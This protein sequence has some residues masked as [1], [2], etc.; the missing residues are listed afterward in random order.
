M[1]SRFRFR[2]LLYLVVA[3]AISPIHAGVYEDFFKG[4]ELDLERRVA[5]LLARGFD[6]NTLSEAGQTPL[7]LALRDGS[8]KVTQ[9]L[10][11]APDLRV[12]QA[13]QVGETAL[14]MAALK[15]DLAVSRELIKRGAKVRRSGWTPLH[16]AASSP[17]VSVVELMLQHG[18]DIDAQAP[19][20]NTALM[21][22][23]RYGEEDSVSLLLARGANKRLLNEL[24]Q[25]A[26]D[27]ARI[28][29]REFL[30]E[31]LN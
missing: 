6:P 22:A 30:V 13:N 29:G 8:P 10:L 18:A 7:Y 16:Y 23:A 20:G 4:V 31:K 24:G 28:S 14:M 27:F 3:V 19:N 9:L 11:A 21:M 5:A 15:G 26:Q 25:S 2:Y 17:Q 12:D 1:K